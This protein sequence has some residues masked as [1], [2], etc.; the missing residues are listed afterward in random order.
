MIGY[1]FEILI[2]VVE[3]ECIFDYSGYNEVIGVCGVGVV[4]FGVVFIGNCSIGFVYW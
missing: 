1:M 2:W 4:V 3:N